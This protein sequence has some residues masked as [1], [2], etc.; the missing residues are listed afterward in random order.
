MSAENYSADGNI[1]DS[2]LE[3]ISRLKNVAEKIQD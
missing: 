1:E 2:V 3:Y